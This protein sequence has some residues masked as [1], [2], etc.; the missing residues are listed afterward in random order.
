MNGTLTNPRTTPVLIISRAN[1]WIV[2]LG[3]VG[4]LVGWTFGLPLLYQFAPRLPAM[5][6]WTAACL[7]ATG[8]ALVGRSLQN[9]LAN[10]IITGIG[11]IAVIGMMGVVLLEYATGFDFGF[12]RW[13]FTKDVQR[14]SP[15]YAG[16]PS[17]QSA[18]AFLALG[19]ALLGKLRTNESEKF[20]RIPEGLMLLSG[21]IALTACFGY[22][23]SADALF[24]L[25]PLK[26]I[27]M[28]P[29]TAAYLILAVVAALLTDPCSWTIMILRQR[30]SGGKLAR[31]LLP[32]FVLVP[33]ALGFLRIEAEQAGWI[34][35][36][37]GTALMAL[38]QVLIGVGMLFWVI[39][40][41]DRTK[42]L[43]QFIT[44]SCVSKRVL[45][46]GKW[47]A[48][49]QYLHDQFHIQT[50]HGMTPEEAETWLNEAVFYANQGKKSAK[51]TA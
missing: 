8:I 38:A 10:K 26:A 24:S 16:R 29:Y 27:G 13:L 44:M 25:P 41:I 45:H 37:V 5:F 23:Y 43:E 6:P 1:A 14:A 22:A 11:A 3:G 15:M 46:D 9:T 47:I 4:G 12:D 51:D 50:S 32:F 19:L 42:T 35:H 48:I 39:R 33:L 2:V 21:C 30:T 40:M 34:S 36:E 31:I 17:L 7:V 28:S 20:N 49:E 18:V